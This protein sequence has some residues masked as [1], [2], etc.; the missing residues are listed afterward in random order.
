[1]KPGKRRARAATLLDRGLTHH[2]AGRRDA[3]RRAYLEAIELQPNNADA[4]QLLGILHQEAGESGE[5]ERLIRAA[6][7]AR[8]E[9]AVYHDNLGAVLES[10]GRLDEALAAYGAAEALEPRVADR[11]YNTALV[12]HRLGRYDAA[13]AALEDAERLAPGDPEVRKLMG[14]VLRARGRP[15]P[16]VVAYRE[17]LARRPGYADARCALATT[18]QELGRLDEALA[19]WL[20]ARE[21]DRSSPRCL[22]ALARLLGSLR[23][24][25]YQPRLDGVLAALLDSEEATAQ[26]LAGAGFAQLALK[27]RL[28]WY[29]DKPPARL[30]ELVP[31]LGADRSLLALLERSV[32]VDPLMERVLARL[33]NCLLEQVALDAP[34]AR[35][36]AVALALQSFNNEYLWCGDEH[37]LRLVGEARATI[38]GAVAQGEERFGTIDAPLVRYA[39]YAP[40]S[41]LECAAALAAWPQHGFGPLVESLIERGL[42]EPAAERDAARSLPV[43]TAMD[44]PTSQAVRA[45][46]EA[47]PYPR[48]LRAPLGQPS[49]YADFLERRFPDFHAPPVLRGPLKVLNAGCGSGQEAVMAALSRPE[50]EILAM[51][52]SRTSLAYASRMAATLGARNIR[53]VQGDVLRTGELGERFAVIESTGVLH[54]LREPMAGWKALR[55]CLAPGGVMKIGLYSRYARRVI[56]AARDRIRELGLAATPDGIRRFRDEVLAGGA[57]GLFAELLHS[58]DFYSLSGCRDLL[59]HVCEHQFT[60][61]EV[62]RALDTLELRLIG[63]E[64]SDPSIA[65][66]YRSEHPDDPKCTDLDGWDRFEQAHPESFAALYVFWCQSPPD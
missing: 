41:R 62:A 64:V 60:W 5:A 24:H 21:A 59:F 42:R 14:D 47:N 26:E 39:M 1:M 8:P 40:L 19:A 9:V 6:I 18:L 48:W 63:I 50:A 49:S 10:G 20:D 17:A 43:G 28:A 61:P 32:N 58:E 7:A 46:Y 56:N 35:R 13:H 2:Q 34:P 57:R 22:R 16:A 45:Q 52:L 23:P 66:R 30:A 4:L 15:Q 51:D 33:R 12:L 55:D 25:A 11:C 54:H 38:E 44:D 29:A 3:A 31:R 36:L 37:E 53:F 65:R 27:Y